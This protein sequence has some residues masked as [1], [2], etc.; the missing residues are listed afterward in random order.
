MTAAAQITTGTNID[1]NSLVS[2]LMSVEE[3]PLQAMQAQQAS[4]KSTI[5]SYGQLSSLLS[6]LN[7]AT[8][9]LQSASTFQQNNATVSDSTVLSATA[10]TSAAAGTHTVTV[11]QLAT[12]QQLASGRF[13]AT[14]DAVGTGTLTFSFGSTD[15]SGNFTVN[16]SKT[17]F[18]VTIDSS[19]NTLAGVAAAINQ[20]NGGVQATVVNDGTGYRLA[21]APTASGAANT[22]KI[23]TTDGDGNNTDAG[24]LSQLAYNPAASAGA[25]KNLTQSTAAQD[26]ALTIDGIAITSSSNSVSAVPGL[27]LNL[28]KTNVG[29]PVTVGVTQNTSAITSAI[30][31]FISSYNSFN[32]T[33]H[34][35]TAYDPTSKTAGSLQGDPTTLSIIRQ[36]KN[37][38]TSP[39]NG[40]A[41]GLSSLSQVGISLQADGSLSLDSSKLNAALANPA[42]NV[43]SLFTSNGAAT[44]SQV[45]FQSALAS[46]PA[47]NYAVNITQPATRAT[48]TGNAAAP[49][50]ITAGVNDTL[51]LTVN[52]QATTVTL[53]AG[54]YATSDALA[55]QIQT[56]INKSAAIVQAGVGIT[57]TQSGGVLSLSSNSYGA[58]SSIGGLG[59]SAAA[60]FGGSPTT[61]AGV[62]VA[63]TINGVAASGSGQTLIDSATGLRLRVSATSAG[64]YGSVNLTYGY[65][66]SLGNLLTSLTDATTG[67]IAIRNKGLNDSINRLQDEQDN[68]NERM[69][70]IEA[71]YRAQFS[72]LDAALSQMKTTSSFL[73]QQL[74]S[75]TSSS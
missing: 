46:T 24:G 18:S 30:N 26:A 5:S 28:T 13:A 37:A 45:K 54:T 47:G 21:L 70:T 44:N 57:V 73:T 27:T 4:Y 9:A 48:L 51:S 35:M 66:S 56:A 20:A 41:G 40:L 43:A 49:L 38:L 67:A 2:Q 68:F 22:L 3:Q 52:G 58:G 31:S 64:N 25:G 12:T 65:G 34:T 39:V 63:G 1:V 59:G 15:G 62:D 14:T 60:L 10:G 7:S 71:N 23:D 8:T 6:N 61:T 19:N 42:I 72:A 17:S 50:T 16:P 74:A 55:S 33:T 53:A 69:T 32:A 29:A 11:S 75:I 36:V